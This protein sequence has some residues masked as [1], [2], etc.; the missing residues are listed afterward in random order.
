MAKNKVTYKRRRPRGQGS[1]YQR[2][3]GRWCGY[4]TITQNGGTKTRKVVYG[5]S[6]MEIAKKLSELSGRIYSNSY[7]L[8]EQNTFGT[9]MFNWL[10]V[11]K[12]SSVAPRTFYG[13]M[14]NFKLHI[15]PRIGNMKLYEIDTYVVQKLINELI[16]KN[17]SANTV[18]KNKH[19]ISQ[20]FEY[21]IDNKWVQVNPV[22]RV[23]VKTAKQS[24]MYKALTPEARAIFLDKLEKDNANFLKPFCI[25]MMF[26]GL[27]VGEAIALQWKN[28][29]PEEKT[30]KVE[31][32]ITMIPKFD[33]NGDVTEKKTV[34]G[35]TKTTCS[36]REIPLVDLVVDELL[37]WKEKQIK[38]QATNPE[39]TAEL[40]A[41]D[42]FI[43]ANDD[44][45][46]R[47]YSGCRKIFDRF[48][49]RNDLNKY[50]IIFHGLRHT[51]SNMLFE[52]NENPK[53]IQQLLG[54]RD[55]KTTITVYNSVDSEYVRNTTDKL[56]E[57]IKQDQL[58]RSQ[59]KRE[60]ELE[61]KKDNLISDMTDDEYDDLLQQLLEERQE[62]KRR[63]K[64]D[65]MEMEKN[66]INVIKYCILIFY[67]I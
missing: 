11:F 9:L 25:T 61:N 23:K 57:K 29:N 18:K 47:T 36:V 2:K 16:D 6:Q 7:D 41:P 4:V 27:R 58:Y 56:N 35:A 51:F 55:V 21:A 62:R 26:A 24:E 44:G 65:E 34:V 17:F 42:S 13:L 12:K 30:L 54:H 8:I 67:P 48:K 15:K 50:H 39:V 49:R 66:I 59:K 31:H 60:E 52:M 63:Q 46:V 3:D 38:R 10:M 22:Y 43:F 45:S 64:E 20:F 32:S 14:K 28:F 37:E 5:K 40:T 53:V 19:L 33:A 1:I